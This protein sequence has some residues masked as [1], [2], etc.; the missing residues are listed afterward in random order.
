MSDSI[1]F[2]NIDTNQYFQSL[3]PHIQET[4]KQGGP[5]ITS[6]EDLR[7]CADNLM[8]QK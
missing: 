1:F 3:P 4:I 8:K 2:Q 5:K 7:R 6:E